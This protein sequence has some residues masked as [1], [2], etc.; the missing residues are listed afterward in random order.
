M[1]NFHRFCL[2]FIAAFTLSACSPK[3]DWREVRSGDAPVLILMPAKPE[4][5]SRPVTLD[6]IKVTMTMTAV[7][8]D[9][10]SF[11]LASAALP[12]PSQAPSALIAMKAAMVKNINGAIKLEKISP[13]APA[14]S[15]NPAAASISSIDIEAT[16]TPAA[17]NRSQP[18]LLLAR[19]IGTE[20]R[21]YQVVVVGPEKKVSREAAETF[22]ASFKLI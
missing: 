17:G 19:F 2:F 21:V 18:M 8:I 9:G 13:V 12:D 20:K 10:V 3:F 11:A 5:M 14:A 22:L 4:T 1:E 6:S 15:G 7:D 16:G